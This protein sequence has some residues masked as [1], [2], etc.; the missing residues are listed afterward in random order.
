[1]KYFSTEFYAIGGILL[2][3]FIFLLLFLAAQGSEPKK[4]TPKDEHDEITF[5][6]YSQMVRKSDN[7]TDDDS[8]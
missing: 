6:G 2:G 7:N 3:L 4:R 5:A 1:M 8:D